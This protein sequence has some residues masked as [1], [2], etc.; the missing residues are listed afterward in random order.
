MGNRLYKL[1][2]G[3][4]EKEIKKIIKHNERYMENEIDRLKNIDNFCGSHIEFVDEENNFS[5]E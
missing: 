1:E 3:M 5:K 2:D 4:T